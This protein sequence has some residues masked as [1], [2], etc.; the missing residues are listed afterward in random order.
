MLTPVASSL[1]RSISKGCHDRAATVM[2]NQQAPEPIAV[3]NG[4]DQIGFHLKLS[5]Q[6][7]VARIDA[8]ILNISDRRYLTLTITFDIIF[9]KGAIVGY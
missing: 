8:A 4:H 1:S 3:Q 5:Q 7:N 6:F 2:G 9:G